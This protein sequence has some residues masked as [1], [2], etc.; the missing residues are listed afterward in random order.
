MRWSLTGNAVP[1]CC[2]HSE[3]RYSSSIQRTCRRSLA[4]RAAVR[5]RVDLVQVGV[6]QVGDLVHQLP[7]ADDLVGQPLAALLQGG[8]VRRVAAQLG[9]ARPRR[10]TRGA[11]AGRAG[12]ACRSAPGAWLMSARPL[13][14]FSARRQASS[15]RST[16]ASTLRSCAS[17][18]WRPRR[19][20]ARRT[21][22]RRAPADGRRRPRPTTAARQS[23]SSSATVGYGDPARPSFSALV[24]P[25]STRSTGVVELEQQQPAYAEPVPRLG[26]V[27]GAEHLQPDRL[28]LVDERRVAAHLVAGPGLRERRLDGA[29]RPGRSRRCGRC[30]LSDATSAIACANVGRSGSLSA[31]RSLPRACSAPVSSTIRYVGRRCSGTLRPVPGLA[32]DDHPGGASGSSARGRRAAARRRAAPRPGTRAPC[33]GAGTKLTRRFLGRLRIRLV[34]SSSRRP[35]TFQEKSSAATRLSVATGTS[36]VSPSSA[37]PGSKW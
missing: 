7:V 33:S 18:S 12:R 4:G 1:S 13:S 31:S 3:T 15:T 10:R 21:P 36:M 16:S 25:S 17:W 29:E 8:E 5:Q 14:A 6:L 26:L 19:R 20:A 28:A 24:R 37:A 22:P 34:T 9:G 2:A 27:L 35:G 11:R 32:R 30:P 23:S